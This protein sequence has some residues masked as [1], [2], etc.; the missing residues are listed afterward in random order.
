M[1]KPAPSTV[2]PG[3]P[4][5]QNDALRRAAWS[6]E[7]PSQKANRIYAEQHPEKPEAASEVPAFNKSADAPHMKGTAMHTPGPWTANLE[8]DHGDFT[9]WG[10]EPDDAFLANIGTAPQENR[11]IAFDVAEANARLIARAPEMLAEI[12]ALRAA[13]KK[14]EEER[15]EF[16]EFVR[17]DQV[18]SI[19]RDLIA[20]AALKEKP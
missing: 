19:Q 2:R 17:R 9:I 7:T 1:S 11:V 3:K 15:D 16:P 8:S 12:A 4:G 14:A 10:P 13:L 5:D 18:L 6:E 20:A